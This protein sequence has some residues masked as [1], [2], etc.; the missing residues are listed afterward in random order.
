MVRL[1]SYLRWHWEMIAYVGLLLFLILWFT[2][3]AHASQTKS[4]SILQQHPAYSVK[5]DD[6]ALDKPINGVASPD[7]HWA[8]LQFRDASWVV[9]DRER[10]LTCY[11]KPHSRTKEDSHGGFDL[12]C[13][14]TEAYR[15]PRS[16]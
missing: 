11:L 1:K 13:R 3:R 9:V 10:H 12:S 14:E 8:V 16:K 7:G 2:P 6:A 15:E 5:E 4:S